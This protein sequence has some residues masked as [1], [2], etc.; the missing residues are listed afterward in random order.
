M[1]EKKMLM[2]I[3]TTAKTRKKRHPITSYS[4]Q[5]T[6]HPQGGGKINFSG[7]E[8]KTYGQNH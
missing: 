7:K 1:S 2:K 8:I 6:V 4:A 3:W 5:G